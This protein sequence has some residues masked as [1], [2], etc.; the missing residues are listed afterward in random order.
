[1]KTRILRRLR[2]HVPFVPSPVDFA[3]V[4]A[5]FSAQVDASAMH[6]SDQRLLWFAFAALS[7]AREHPERWTAVRQQLDRWLAIPAGEVS[8][9]VFREWQAVM[10]TGQIAEREDAILEL[11][12]RGRRLRLVSPLGALFAGEDERQRA[13]Q[14]YHVGPP[15]LPPPRDSAS[16]AVNNPAPAGPT[17]KRPPV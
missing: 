7:V 16:F 10:D 8:Q 14:A 1:M 6:P 9:V 17:R 4:L 3:L 11:T 2:R 12:P 5:R 13:M 15:V